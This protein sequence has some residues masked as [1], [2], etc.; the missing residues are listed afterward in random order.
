MSNGMIV[1]NKF[2]VDITKENVVNISKINYNSDKSIVKLYF[3][4][5]YDYNLFSFDYFFN[6]NFEKI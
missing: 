6:L 2:N 4:Q 5:K 3:K 1:D